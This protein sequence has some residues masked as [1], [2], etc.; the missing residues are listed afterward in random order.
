MSQPRKNT[1]PFFPPVNRGT[2]SCGTALRCPGDM[3]A[4][5]LGPAPQNCPITNLVHEINGGPPL[6]AG[7][8]GGGV[9]IGNSLWAIQQK[10]ASLAFNPKRSNFRY[11]EKI[12]WQL[13]HGSRGPVT[14]RGW[15]MRTGQRIWF[16]HPLPAPRLKPLEVGPVIAL[17]IS[18]DGARG[19]ASIRWRAAPTSPAMPPDAPYHRWWHRN[20][21]INSL[22]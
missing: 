1:R 16:G 17:P 9:L 14:L 4:R 6:G 2:L 20:S 18:R 7:V 13:I 15:N 3:V 8:A 21:Q 19:R 12:Y 5:S 22:P 11:G 10:H